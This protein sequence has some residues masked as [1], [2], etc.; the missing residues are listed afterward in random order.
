MYAKA[1][2]KK[3]EKKQKNSSAK[4]VSLS[5][6]VCS[7]SVSFQLLIQDICLVGFDDVAHSQ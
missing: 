5:L 7:F 6:S 1:V 3:K 4:N 2:V